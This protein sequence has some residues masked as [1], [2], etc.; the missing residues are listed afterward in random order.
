MNRTTQGQRSPLRFRLSPGTRR[1]QELERRGESGA[2]LLL[3]LAFI[4]IVM[5]L[6]IALL[7]LAK[8][9]NSALRSYRTER[10]RR[11]AVD[12]ALQEAIQFMKQNPKYGTDTST[13]L[14]HLEH[15]VKDDLRGG[16]A[17]I[18]PVASDNVVYYITVD[19]YATK[20]ANVDSGAIG[21]DGGQDARDVTFEVKC[22]HEPNTPV[23]VG[24]IQCG[25]GTEEIVLARARIRFD[26]DYSIPPTSPDCN[27]G[28]TA[29][30]AR[31]VVPKVIS[32]S[33]RQ[34]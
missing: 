12:G 30:T 11:Y 6:T 28:C 20:I 22:S 34:D 7:G 23:P 18:F 17:G 10:V 9:E 1:F 16:A 24:L 25:S 19:C 2:I 32:W 33:V 14:C 29:S 3:A 13:D 4:T 8:T 21:S 5:V 27:P 31:A 15:P 26:V